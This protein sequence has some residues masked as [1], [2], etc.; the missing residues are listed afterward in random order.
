MRRSMLF[1]ACLGVAT[2]AAQAV[3]LNTAA[4]AEIEAVKGIGPDLAER[5]LIERDRR[6]F[7]D[8]SD[9]IARVRG[10][11]RANAARLSAEGLTVNGNALERA[12]D[13]SK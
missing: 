8:W 3:E 7:K 12:S 1:A 13:A 6:G 2:L 5:L 11:G 10:I 4:R 9:L